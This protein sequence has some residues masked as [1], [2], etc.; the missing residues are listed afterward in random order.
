MLNKPDI[1]ASLLCN[2]NIVDMILFRM[3]QLIGGG[4]AWYYIINMKWKKSSVNWLHNSDLF[5]ADLEIIQMW[6]QEAMFI[7]YL[8]LG[9]AVQVVSYSK[10]ILVF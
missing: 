6:R 10:M 9:T 4:V 2:G 8:T 1:L 5:Y 3:L 7:R